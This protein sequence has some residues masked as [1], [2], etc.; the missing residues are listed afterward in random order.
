MLM[1]KRHTLGDRIFPYLLL[2]PALLIGAIVLLYPLINGVYLS[3]TGYKII[4]PMYNWRGIKN[5]LELFRDPVFREV[6]LNSIVIVFSSVAIQFTLGFTMALLLNTKIKFQGI[7]RSLVFII[8]I[9]PEMVAALLF[10]IIY[11]SDF[12]ILNYVLK[13]IGLIRQSVQW[14]G[15]PVA[16]KLALIFV[17]G[18]RGIP[19]HMVMLLAALQTV[20]KDLLEAATIDGA[21]RFR[22]FTSVTLPSISNIIALCWLLSIVRA[23]QDVTQIFILTKGGPM[24]STTTLAMHVYN[25]AFTSFNM[26]KAA[27]VGVTWMVFL[28]I[29]AVFYIRQISKAEAFR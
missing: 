26:G 23:F 3:F 8:W 22:Q 18:W 14:L 12:G 4:R 1:T 20:P 19:F 9:I 25:Y 6:F 21:G 2:T 27:A 29:I 5:Y 13:E 16:A 24:H 17:Y 10:M 15:E 11:N 28:L 7:F